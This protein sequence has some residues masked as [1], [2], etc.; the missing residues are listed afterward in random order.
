MLKSDSIPRLLLSDFRVYGPKHV[1]SSA[2]ERWT[3]VDI[4]SYARWACIRLLEKGFEHGGLVVSA[5]ISPILGIALTF[6][7]LCVGGVA[8]LG[9]WRKAA[10]T[11]DRFPCVAIFHGYGKGETVRETLGFGGEK[12][13]RFLLIEEPV[14]P[15]QPPRRG[16]D[17]LKDE[18]TIE[19]GMSKVG[20]DSDAFLIISNDSGQASLLTEKQALGFAREVVEMLGLGENDAI[21]AVTPP[22]SAFGVLRGFLPAMISQS[23]VIFAKE[24]REFEVLLK[25]TLPTAV[26]VNQEESD[27]CLEVLAALFEHKTTGWDKVI[28]QKLQGKGFLSSLVRFGHNMGVFGFRK[29]KGELRFVVFEGKANIDEK[30]QKLLKA[31]GIHFRFLPSIMVSNGKRVDIE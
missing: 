24:P 12:E 9:E 29:R 30:A 18:E 17:S 27:A 13:K 26:V 14:E 4:W 20:P 21:I 6:G 7:G 15:P 31:L 22:N 19:K 8:L 25:S 23:L 5:D 16:L 1:V 11:F 3:F 28:L 2:D 10:K